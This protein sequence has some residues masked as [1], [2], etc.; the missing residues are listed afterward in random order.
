MRPSRII[1][2]GLHCV[3][4]ILLPHTPGASEP[5]AFQSFPD[6]RKYFK[7]TFTKCLAV[8]LWLILTTQ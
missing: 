2:R 7:V 4:Q 5:P 3:P 1:P 8:G 6:P